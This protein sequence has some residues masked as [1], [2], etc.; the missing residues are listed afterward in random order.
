VALDRRWIPSPNYSSRGGATPRLLVVHT[1]E[2]ARTIE[3]LGSYFQNPAA[4]V[5]SHAGIDDQAGIC[6]EYVG[7]GWSAWTQASYNGAAIAVELC[8]FAA[9][10]RA[11]WLRHPAM[12]E[13]CRLW[14]LEES[15]AAGIPLVRLDAGA[16][17]GGARGVCGHNELG[18][19]GG[20]HWDPGPDFPWDVVLG[21]APRPPDP[22]KPPET[23][24]WQE[25]ARMICTDPETGGVWAVDPRDGHVEAELGAPYRGGLGPGNRHNWEAVGR[26]AG[27]APTE[28]GYRIA[29]L[30]PA[31]IPEGM[32]GAGRWFSFYHFPED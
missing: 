18:A 16:A 26:I 28:G 27:I 25:V 23:P 1:A 8:A 20:G 9:W 19:G 14:L 10:D 15:A 7:R 30:R 12:L 17:Q 13:N 4:E 24:D 3:A 29:V 22:P 5:S 21:P 6:G 11:E 32:P 31:P 2:G